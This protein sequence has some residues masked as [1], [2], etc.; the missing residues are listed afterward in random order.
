LFGELCRGEAP[1]ENHE[2]C[3]CFSATKQR[4]VEIQAI[5]AQISDE[6][7]FVG[8]FGYKPMRDLI[9]RALKGGERYLALAGYKRGALWI[10]AIVIFWKIAK[11][12]N[13][14]I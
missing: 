7:T 9:R 8:A 3:S 10:L 14:W 11:R 1:V 12:L 6:L 4:E 13:F 5:F 2:S